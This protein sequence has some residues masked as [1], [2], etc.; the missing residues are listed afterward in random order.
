MNLKNRV[1]KKYRILAQHKILVIDDDKDICQVLKE[2]LDYHDMGMDCCSSLNGALHKLQGNV[3]R[4][5]IVDGFVGSENGL[6]IAEKIKEKY[7]D[8]KLVF[9]S[10]S[11]LSE[12][13][14]IFEKCF[15][16]TDIDGL[17]SFLNR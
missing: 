13:Y 15:K 16:K 17:M 14:S 5:I 1:L 6:K 11:H 7:P 2:H 8:S 12:E 9:Y 4:Y 10:G 3:Y